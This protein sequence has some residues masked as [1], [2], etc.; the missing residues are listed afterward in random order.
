MTEKKKTVLKVILM[1][2]LKEKLA[3]R[4]LAHMRKHSK[5]IEVKKM[6]I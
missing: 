6:I 3:H 4:E 5:M 2:T 1:Y